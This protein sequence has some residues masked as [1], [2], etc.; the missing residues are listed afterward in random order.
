[1]PP[2]S[3]YQPLAIVLTAVAAGIVVDRE[4]APSFGLQGYAAAVGLVVWFVARRRHSDRFASAALLA[5]AAAMGG[6]WHHACWRLFDVDDP[7]TFAA[8]EPRPLLIEA[9]VVEAPRVIDQASDEAASGGEVKTRFEIE[10]RQVRDGTVWRRAAGRSDVQIDD[11]VEGV[12]AGDV[13]HLLGRIARASP[14]LNPGEF[15]FAAHFRSER[16]LCF[17]RAARAD[18]ITVVSRGS[19][20]NVGARLSNWRRRGHRHLMEIVPKAQSGFASALLLGYRDQL[21]RRENWAFFRTGTVHILSISGL[22]IGML[23]LFL[24]WSLRIGWLRRSSALIVTSVVTTAY[25]LVIDAEPPAVRA[26]LAVVL[27]S[28]AAL[29]LRRPP[30][31]NLLAAAALVVLAMNPSDLFRAGPQ[32]SFLAAAVLAWSARQRRDGDDEPLDRFSAS[33]ID[34]LPTVVR[35]TIEGLGRML[36]V[37]TAIFAA[38]GPLVAH[39]FHIV[40]PV[41]LI[42]TPLV[43]LPTAA[44]L[45]AGFLSLTLGGLVPPLAAPLG[46]ICGWSLAA[47]EGLVGRA[48]QAAHGWFWL[49]GPS[50]GQVAAFYVLLALWSWLPRGERP[51]RFV[52][53]A[54]IAWGLLTLV[55]HHSLPADVALRTTFISV[56]HGL[57]VLVE[58]ADGPTWLYDCGRFGAAERGAQSIAGVLWSRGITRLDAIVV[59]H[60]DA[61]HYNG[62]P[63]LVEQFAVD[64][65]IVSQVT[66]ASSQPAAEAIRRTAAAA[67]VPIESL[68]AGEPLFADARGGVS[69]RVLHPP[70]EGVAGN[71]NAQ[72]L[73]VELSTRGRRLL[74]TGDVEGAGLERILSESPI[75][76][77]VLLAPHHGSARSN[78]PDLA[79]WS[80]PEF[81]I[82]SGDE[83]RR[84]VVRRAYEAVGAVLLETTE[85][86]AVTVDVDRDGGLG[87]E[88]FRESIESF[89]SADR[90]FPS[91]APTIPSTPPR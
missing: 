88:T 49:P 65:L 86:G 91:R 82:V 51:R 85:V 71:D 35:R 42:L 50:A 84:G 11:V 23:A 81:V 76:C 77:D 89:A 25:V 67:G 30:L 41:A 4:L 46:T 7:A 52:G 53:A 43:A 69:H 32:L 57:S 60:L 10:V 80:R 17:V 75:D 26:A 78:P 40:S 45:F 3:R 38:A 9:T 31:G 74:L 1:M 36:F 39:R 37:S 56:G 58:E 90:N 64:R 47:C 68:S 70:P 62:L 12:S 24:H 48:Q 16:K 18:A 28:T 21:D 29:M 33:R 20:W 6:A 19:P 5:S 54:A 27:A 66:F 61:D 83:D 15:D 2:P 73:V 59:S 79:A 87:V 72:S 34:R 55:P 14:P 63:L 13:V 8:L 44:A 22:H